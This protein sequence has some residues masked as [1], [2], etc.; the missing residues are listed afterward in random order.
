MLALL[1]LSNIIFWFL[2]F[3]SGP[4]QPDRVQFKLDR[5]DS[6]QFCKEL[7]RVCSCSPKAN[8]PQRL[9][10][11]VLIYDHVPDDQEHGEQ[12]VEPVAGGGRGRREAGG[13][14]PERGPA[15]PR[16][17]PHHFGWRSADR[18]LPGPLCA[19]QHQVAQSDDRR[20][21]R[22]GHTVCGLPARRPEAHKGKGLRQHRWR[23][24]LWKTGC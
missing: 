22:G 15:G 4:V 10:G 6:G 18:H 12:S 1:F 21:Q 11:R 23:D 14:A 24:A 16:V 17:L 9:P 20:G 7:S 8:I 5:W 2:I 13:D 3:G 19:L